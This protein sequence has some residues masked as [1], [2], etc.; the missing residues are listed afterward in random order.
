M[1]RLVKALPYNNVSYQKPDFTEEEIIVSAYLH[2]FAKIITYCE[3]VRDAWRY[4]DIELPSE[5]WTLNELA[6]SGIG[7]SDNELN[8]LLYAEGG[9]S[10]FKEHI[11]NLKP[12]A[13]LLHMADL[14]SAKVLCITEEVSCPICGASMKKRHSGKDGSIFYG[15]NRYP[16]CNG[17]KNPQDINRERATLKEKLKNYKYL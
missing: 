2:D 4:N 1:F 11:K 8:A 9:W 3:D 7:L 12:L 15:C 6:K 17:T 5:I 13:V 16:N 10:E 14:W